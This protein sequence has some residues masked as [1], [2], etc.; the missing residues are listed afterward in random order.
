LK[1]DIQQ[2]DWAAA[3]GERVYRFTRTG[4]S[5]MGYDFNIKKLGWNIG[6]LP[7]PGSKTT[8]CLNMSPKYNSENTFAYLIL[9]K[10]RASIRM[11]FDAQAGQFCLENVPQG[12]DAEVMIVSKVGEKWYSV[13]Q[14]TNTSIGQLVLDP[15]EKTDVEVIETVKGL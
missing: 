10:E 1:S 6:F 13:L 11:P 15:K 3:A 9:K 5:E 2:V 12:L 7:I 14:T 4:T 8:F